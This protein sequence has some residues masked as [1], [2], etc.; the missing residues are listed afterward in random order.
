MIRGDRIKARRKMLNMTQVELADAV[1]VKQGFLSRVEAGKVDVS[2]DT[3]VAL[4]R[5]L[6][7]RVG[8]L[9]GVEDHDEETEH[10]AAMAL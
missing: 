6:R 3:L 2:T 7:T 1:G 4:A 9:L 8:E 10:L 5:A